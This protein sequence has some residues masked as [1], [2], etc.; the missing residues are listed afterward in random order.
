M[1]N[2][3]IYVKL[4]SFLFNFNNDDYIYLIIFSIILGI[5]VSICTFLFRL[6]FETLQIIFYG[7]SLDSTSIQLQNIPWY[8]TLL[9]PTFGGLVIG[10]LIYKFMPNKRPTGIADLMT[11]NSKLKSNYSIILAI[12]GAL[13]N[14]LSLGIGASVGSVGPI[15]HIGGTIGYFFSSKLKSNSDFITIMIACGVASAISTLFNAPIAGVIFALEIIVKKYNIETFVPILLSS[16]VSTIISRLYFGP[17]TTFNIPQLEFN[18]FMELPLFIILGTLCSVI[19]IIFIKLIFSCEN[20]YNRRNIPIWTRPGIGGVVVGLIAIFAPEILG[21]G[22]YG[23]NLALS[24]S[25]PLWFCIV[26]VIGKTGAT[27]ICLGSRFGGGIFIPSIFIGT[28]LGSCFGI[29]ANIYFPDFASS[30]GF[31]TLIGMGAVAAPILGAPISL[32]MIT[33][34]LT[35]QYEVIIASMITVSISCLI[36]KRTKLESFFKT[37]L[38]IRKAIEK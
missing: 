30:I 36:Y 23:T 29:I 31:Y 34:E 16:A 32:I 35:G 22:Y 27:G 2:K 7:V 33:F 25:I 26:L 13:I 19:A 6:C 11:I 24:S 15:V 12:K 21:V 37:Q 28:M 4:K 1:E 18:S 17:L 20:F 9:V 8:I 5:L 10:I 38:Y 3:N 14:T